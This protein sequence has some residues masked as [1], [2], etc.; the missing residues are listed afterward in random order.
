ME[1]K[2]VI[3]P[4]ERMAAAYKKL[5]GA[6]ANL[7]VVS[8]ELGKSI[9]ALDSSLKRLNLGVSTWVTLVGSEDPYGNFWSRDVGYAKVNDKWGIALRTTS[10]NH[11]YEDF[12]AEEWLFNDAPRHMRIEAVDELPSLLERLTTE[13][14]E[15]AARIKEKTREAHELA[16]ALNP[17]PAAPRK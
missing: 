11:N 3:P 14:D 9:A 6:A 13:A 1:S 17:K 12:A 2:P 8:D 4:S 10:G 16:A 7:N 5:S 15:T